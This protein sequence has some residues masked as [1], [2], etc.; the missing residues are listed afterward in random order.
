MALS[1]SVP[2]SC[3]KTQQ[4]QAEIKDSVTNNHHAV[5]RVRRFVLCVRYD[6]GIVY[7]LQMFRQTNFKTQKKIGCSHGSLVVSL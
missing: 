4:V 6:F 7:K 2:Y 3:L 1:L 5:P